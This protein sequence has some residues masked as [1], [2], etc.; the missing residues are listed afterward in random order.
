MKEFINGGTSQEAHIGTIAGRT[1]RF[2]I[3]AFVTISTIA[4]WAT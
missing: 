2:I 1:M 3:V 4:Y